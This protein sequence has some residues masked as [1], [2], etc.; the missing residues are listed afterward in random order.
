[1]EKT[2][3]TTFNKKLY[4]KYAYKLIESYLRTEQKI[5][6]LC[7]VED[8]TSLYP[9]HIKIKYLNL[10]KE[11]PESLKFYKRN[12][13]KNLNAAKASYLLDAVRFSYKVYAQNDSRKYADYIFY[14]DSDTEFKNQIPDQWFQDCLPSDTFISIFDRLGFYTET[15]FVAFNNVIKN[16]QGGKISDSFFKLYLQYYNNDLIFSLPAFTDCHALD[17]TR[18][19]FRFLTKIV[20]EYSNYKEK[21]LGNWLTKRDFNVMQ[22]EFISNYIIHMKGNIKNN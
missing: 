3:I 14:I 19:R 15:G 9:T 7:Y 21:H 6:L 2:F 13:E 11:Q 1:M 16:K 8:D 22:D 17:A 20:L 5:N 4:D 18:W 12:F 10:F